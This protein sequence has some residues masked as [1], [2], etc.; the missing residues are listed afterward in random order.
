MPI[1]LQDCSPWVNDE[2]QLY[3][4]D[5]RFFGGFLDARQAWIKQPEIGTL[6]LMFN[7]NNEVL[8]QLKE[9]PGN[10]LG[11]QIAP[12][13]QSTRSNTDRVHGGKNQP[14]RDFFVGEKVESVKLS[15]SLQSEQG[16]RFWRKRNRNFILKVAKKIDED[17]SHRWFLIDELRESLGHSFL[18]NT[19]ARS[20][21]ACAPWDLF[22]AQPSCDTGSG[23]HPLLAKVRRDYSCSPSNAGEAIGYL[24]LHTNN[25]GH[26]PPARATRRVQQLEDSFWGVN[27]TGF[28]FFH[29]E[30]AFRE[31]RQWNQPL[32]VSGQ[33]QSHWL[34]CSE[35]EGVIVFLLRVV[36]E[37][38]LFN[39]VEYGPSL[40]TT[41][42]SW[43]SET[44]SSSKMA[45]EHLLEDQAIIISEIAQSDE[46]GRFFEEVA[47]YRL[48]WLEP[49]QAKALSRPGPTAEQEAYY[50]VNPR[51][52]NDLCGTSLTTTNELRTLASLLVN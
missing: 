15:D 7:D 26:I 33:T 48:V 50:W 34:V 17:S 13:F 20:T 40:S 38:G 21:V 4:P 25:R 9:E 10:V 36:F 18:V 45:L 46:G 39:R 8:L 37:R 22:F 24:K 30:A 16:T 43:E 52:L 32:F 5:K 3:R 28:R 42:N 6:G 11:S 27:G 14:Y 29:V 47:N 31:I 35:I 19:D 12:T 44:P 1:R 49:E 41:S 2:A 51:G 23:G